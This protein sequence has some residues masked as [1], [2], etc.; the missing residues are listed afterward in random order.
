VYYEIP[1]KKV[2]FNPDIGSN[3][4]DLLENARVW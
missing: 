3:W 2:V 4:S 1:K